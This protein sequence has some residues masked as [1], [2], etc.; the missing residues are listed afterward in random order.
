MSLSITSAFDSGNIIV[1]ALSDRSDIRLDIRIDKDSEFY[2]WFHFRLSG[3]KGKPCR[4]VI[5]NAGASAYP[6][7]WPDYQVCASYDRKTWFR[8]PTEYEAGHLI[9][10]HTPSEGAVYYAYFAPFSMERHADMVAEAALLEGVDLREL[11][12][13]LDGR[14]LDCLEVGEGDKHVWVIARQHPGE[15]MAEWLVEGLLARLLDEADPVARKLRK[16]AR[17]HIVPNMN[18]DG[19]FRGH[20]RTNAAGVNLNRE[21]AGPSLE[22]SPEVYHTLAAMRKSGVDLFLDVHGD[23]ALPYN[24]IAGAEGAPNFTEADDARLTAYKANLMKASP[25]FQIKHGYPRN[26]AGKANMKIAGNAVYG[27]FQCLAMTL[28]MP[29]KDN[30]DLPDP[31]YG[32]SPERC[33]ILGAANLDSMLADLTSG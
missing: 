14:A 25:D 3:A 28:E 20:L 19:S 16:I 26:A 2:Q 31:A 9:I 13:S 33:R 32:W 24:F 5:E 7:G 10:S 8:V 27:Y 22:N 18:P 4:M 11:G 17:F 30:A 1:K 12:H 15:S 29:F 21:W 6:G 23:E